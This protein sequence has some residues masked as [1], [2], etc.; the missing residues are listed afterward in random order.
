MNVLV[1]TNMYPTAADLTYGCFVKE[2]I[3]SVRSQGVSC[4]VTFINGKQTRVN[5]F[6]SLSPITKAACSNKYDLIHAHYGLSGLPSRLQWRL[7]LIVSFC[8]DDLL[9]SPK[10][11]G[12]STK[13]SLAIRQLSRWVGRLSECVIVKSTEMKDHLPYGCKTYVVPNGVDLELFTPV[14]QT[15]AR[16]TL[17]LN[18]DKKYL[19]FAANPEVTVKRFELAKA[20]FDQVKLIIPDCTLLTVHGKTRHEFNLYLNAADCLLLTSHH[21]G[22]PN[23]IKEAMACNL[24]IV[25]VN[26]GDVED[27]ISNTHLCYAT[28]NN[29][30]EMS[31]RV[32]EVL[33]TGGRSNGRDQIRHLDIGNVAKRIIAIYEEVLGRKVI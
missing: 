23:V 11:D 25:S 17:G 14:E 7:P 4:D 26:V 1:V 24:P 8:G 13:R 30:L 16:R 5:Y 9:G 21:E 29:P 33:G 12:S 22:S 2:Q 3:D 19:L 27:I 10:T 20:V 18:L 32:L 28:R 6:K 15:Q 31:Q